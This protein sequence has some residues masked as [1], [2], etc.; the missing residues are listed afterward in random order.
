MDNNLKQLLIAITSSVVFSLAFGFLGFYDFN[1]P[2]IMGLLFLF[3][4][5]FTVIF[6]LFLDFVEDYKDC[7]KRLEEINDFN[8]FLE[9]EGFVNDKKEK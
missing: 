3:F 6:L 4:L 5:Q 1:Y 7:K 9:G 2:A 8:K